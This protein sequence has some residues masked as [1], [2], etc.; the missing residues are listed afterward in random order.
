M[1][2]RIVRDLFQV[3]ALLYAAAG[4][5]VAPAAGARRLVPINT[6]DLT[7]SQSLTALGLSPRAVY[8][9]CFSPAFIFANLP[10]GPPAPT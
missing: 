5:I 3:V 1:T 7:R 4:A 2:V 6:L 10:R 9:I 8:F